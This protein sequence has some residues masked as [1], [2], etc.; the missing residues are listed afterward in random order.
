MAADPIKGSREVRTSPYD[1]LW[2]SSARERAGNPYRPSGRNLVEIGVAGSLTGS[3]WVERPNSPKEQFVAEL[4]HL[5]RE[6]GLSFAELARRLGRPTS[7]VHGWVSGRHLP[8]PREINTVLELLALLN[9]DDPGPIVARLKDLQNGERLAD[10]TH[11]HAV[12]AGPAA[13]ELWS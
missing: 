1:S 4:T 13:S 11:S 6:R 8:Y 2:I 5:K 9:V 7:T 3:G 10:R 12:I